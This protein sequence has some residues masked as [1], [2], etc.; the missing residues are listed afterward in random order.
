MSLG[1]FEA[2]TSIKTK[3]EKQEQPESNR[4]QKGGTK[5]QKRTQSGVKM[6]KMARYTE[7]EAKLAFKEEDGGRS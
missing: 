6:E 4:G 3:A 1:V 5:E 2:G 7:M